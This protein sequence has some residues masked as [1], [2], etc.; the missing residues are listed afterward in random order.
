MGVQEGESE[1]SSK[2][3]Q[4]SEHKAQHVGGVN[5]SSNSDGGGY[6]GAEAWQTAKRIKYRSTTKAVSQGRSSHKSPLDSPS[7]ATHLF[8]LTQALPP[9][10]PYL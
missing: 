8:P 9:A 3:Q 7:S 10:T 4:K 2:R 6:Y 5:S 1:K